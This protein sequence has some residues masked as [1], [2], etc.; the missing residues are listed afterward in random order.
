MDPALVEFIKQYN[1]ANKTPLTKRELEELEVE[2]FLAEMPGG[3]RLD[4]TEAKDG[5]G[6]DGL[7]DD[8]FN[9]GMSY[10]RGILSEDEWETLDLDSVRETLA[11]WLG[12]T[13]E[14]LKSIYGPGGK[15]AQD[16]EL[17]VQIDEKLL[18]AVE[19]GASKVAIARVLGW[20]LKKPHNQS[21]I[22]Q[23]ALK[24]ARKARAQ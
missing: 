14:D 1:Q 20:G 21:P 9:Y 18:Q 16:L 7:V 24:R 4:P 17:R 19:G 8:P 5:R 23:K 6:I 15:T 10:H 22:L 11:S 12:A 3:I 13:L 2:E